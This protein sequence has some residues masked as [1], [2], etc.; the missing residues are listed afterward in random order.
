MYFSQCPIGLPAIWSEGMVH[1]GP[2]IRWIGIPTVVL[3][4]WQYEPSAQELS[5]LSNVG[6]FKVGLNVFLQLGVMNLLHAVG[7]NP[8]IATMGRN[9]FQCKDS[10]FLGTVLRS[11]SD[12]DGN[13][14]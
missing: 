12:F 2:R 8:K 9:V 14:K 3:G 1:E 7:P 4:W 13:R 11:T 10:K 6:G 5:N